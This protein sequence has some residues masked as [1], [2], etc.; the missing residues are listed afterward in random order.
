MTF[1][2][3]STADRAHP[4]DE[5][6]NFLHLARW[7]M[8]AYLPWFTLGAIAWTRLAWRYT[9]AGRHASMRAE[10]VAAG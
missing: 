10:W 7:F 9:R 1:L 5:W 4:A 6:P 2:R 3:N 8:F